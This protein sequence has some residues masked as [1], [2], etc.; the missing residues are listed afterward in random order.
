VLARNEPANIREVEIL[1]DQETPL[2]LC[3]IPDS[4]VIPTN[5]SLR[6]SGVNVMAQ[7]SQQARQTYRHVLIKFD[8]HATFGKRGAGRSSCA[9]VAANA[10]AARTSS[11]ESVGKS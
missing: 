4:V 3:R 11:S 8:L 1:C 2:F 9:D 5:K 7:I 10:I 6:L